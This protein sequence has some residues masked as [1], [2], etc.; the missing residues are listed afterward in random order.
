VLPLPRENW[1]DVGP[2]LGVLVTGD[3][4]GVEDGK[5][6]V[7]GAAVPLGDLDVL[8][9]AD[10]LSLGLEL[11]KNLPDWRRTLGKVDC[12]LLLGEIDGTRLG[13]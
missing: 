9:D 1:V 7:F 5:R 4:L 13:G 3:S 10:G 11:G 8:G 12:L 2:A 6:V